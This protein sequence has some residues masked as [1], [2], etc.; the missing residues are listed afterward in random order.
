MLICDP[1]T[2]TEFTCEQPVPEIPGHQLLQLIGTGATSRVWRAKHV[3]LNEEVAIKVRL[4][5]GEQT[6]HHRFLSEAQLARTW[7]HRSVM[8]VFDVGTTSSGETFFT[9]P[10]GSHTLADLVHSPMSATQCADLITHIGQA[11][12]YIHARSAVHCDVKPSNIV[13]LHD[14]PDSRWC[15]TDFGC[16]VTPTRAQRVGAG[17][18]GYTAHEQDTVGPVT[19]HADQFAFATVIAE[20]IEA[21]PDRATDGRLLDVLNRAR[22]HTANDRYPTIDRFVD[23][24]L[25]SFARAKIPQHVTNRWWC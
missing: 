23:E 13:W 20:L 7:C 22:A 2:V 1:R 24:L 10:L 5:I 3:L 14:S 11:L 6:D 15:L 17:T 8:R 21:S 12:S 19:H 16:A 4:P 9:M 25:A 18:F